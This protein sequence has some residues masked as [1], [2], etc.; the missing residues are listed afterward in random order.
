M[1]VVSA[2]NLKFS[3][4]IMRFAD[5]YIYDLKNLHDFW[6]VRIQEAEGADYVCGDS[7][8]KAILKAYQL[9]TFSPLQDL[10]I[11]AETYHSFFKT[12]ISAKNIADTF[13]ILRRLGLDRLGNLN[14]LP[15]SEIQARF[16]KTWA[17]FFQGVISPAEAFWKW[18]PYREK[19]VFYLEHEFENLCADCA[20]LME[21][22]ENYLKKLSESEPNLQIEKLSLQFVTYETTDDPGFDLPTTYPY[23]L[24]RDQLWIFKLLHERVLSLK[25]SSPISKILFRIHSTDRAESLQLSLFS[26][27]LAK[28]LEYKSLCEKLLNEKFDVFV[29]EILPSYLPETSWKKTQPTKEIQIPNYGLFR[30]LIQ[31]V[32]SP[33]APPDDLR[34]WFTERL[35]WFDTKG[36]AH[37]RD[38]FISR[39]PQRWIWIFQDEN[40]NW[41][42][43]GVIE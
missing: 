26:N 20:E 35:A 37:S 17:L 25:F 15:F 39:V 36:S 4:Y 19:E 43:Q 32:P 16:G 29:P 2:Q 18:I 23:L 11:F 14:R 10:K 1:F 12:K 8:W 42:R 28:S 31:E 30:P 40:Q 7:L 27:D 22:I 41:F 13:A 38:Y 33:I 5:W 6:K 24:S 34:I 3:P 21:P 9:Q